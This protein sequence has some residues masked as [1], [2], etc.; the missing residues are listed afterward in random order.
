MYNEYGFW[1]KKDEVQ[2]PKNYVE[3]TPEMQAEIDRSNAA[4]QNEELAKG[5]GGDNK[6]DLDKGVTIE[7][8][9]PQRAY[10]GNGITRITNPDGSVEFE[11][12]YAKGYNGQPQLFAEGTKVRFLNQ[13]KEP[14]QPFYKRAL[15]W[16]GEQ[17]DALNEWGNRKTGG[18]IKGLGRGLATLA[19]VGGAAVV[20]T[21]AAGSAAVV[22]GGA[23]LAGAGALAS[24]SKE[25]FEP[26]PVLI[27]VTNRQMADYNVNFLNNPDAAEIKNPDV[28]YDEDTK[29]LT[30][31]KTGETY[32]LSRKTADGAEFKYGYDLEG[33]DTV[34]PYIQIGD[35]IKL[36]IAPQND[37]TVTNVVDYINQIGGDLKT[38]EGVG[39]NFTVNNGNADVNFDNGLI[40][41][42]GG[43]T[44]I[45]NGSTTKELYNM[46]YDMG[47]NVSP[48]NN[49][50]IV[51][52]TKVGNKG[53]YALLH[54][55][56]E[57]A[58]NAEK[59]V[60]SMAL[61]TPQH[62]SDV[63]EGNPAVKGNIGSL[64]FE[65]PVE[66]VEAGQ[67][68]LVVN[69]QEQDNKGGILIKDKDG[70]EIYLQRETDFDTSFTYDGYEIPA[71]QAGTSIIAF[72]K[73]GENKFEEKYLM[74]AY[75][76][77]EVNMAL[78]DR[79]NNGTF[80][81]YFPSENNRFDANKNAQEAENYYREKEGN[82]EGA[83]DIADRNFRYLNQWS[84]Y[85]NAG[86]SV[87]Y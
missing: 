57:T 65:G 51:T 12:D 1:P 37:I 33:V 48:D 68:K 47:I 64:A 9:Q 44:T 36:Y 14:E 78:I 85:A 73:T 10:Q 66:K 74:Q 43:A 77:T 30:D 25:D 11:I 17:I 42:I 40:H 71:T 13:P 53:S 80:V 63:V 81:Q 69:G 29:V 2:Q 4:R 19:T 61:A 26:D 5:L 34:R 22:K 59:P 31:Y 20:G 41:T 55:E 3:I 79:E 32:D 6:P 45:Q 72:V 70:K 62:I 58:E 50:E 35:K 28:F 49:T 87:E 82:L 60:F 76:D 15:A 54:N 86:A 23:A 16:V 38:E 21:A 39:Y 75:S 46:F 18:Q 83:Q 24:C 7:K 8:G 56:P 27:T 52:D 67:F 84:M